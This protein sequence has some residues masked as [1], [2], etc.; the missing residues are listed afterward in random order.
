VLG[1]GG[2]PGYAGGGV[3][4]GT[5]DGAWVIADLFGGD[6]WDWAS[7]EDVKFFDHDLNFCRRGWRDGRGMRNEI[8]ILN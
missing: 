8:C 7:V 3:S 2:H 5:V 6:L 1:S 4:G